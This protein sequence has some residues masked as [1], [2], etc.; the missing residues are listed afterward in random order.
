MRLSLYLEK[1]VN[2]SRA[3]S[4]REDLASDPAVRKATYISPERG[5]KEFEKYSGLGE[6]LSL[7]S[8]NPLPGVI[9]IEP[10]DTSSL[11]VSNL[12]NRLVHIGGIQEVRVDSEWLKRLNAMLELGNRI[13]NGVTLLIVTAVVLAV[14][15]TIRLLVANRRDEIRVTKLVGGSDGYVMLPFLYSGFWYGLLGGVLGWIMTA[16][17]WLLVSQPATHLASLYH[18]AFRPSFPGMDITL[19]LVVGGAL[20]GVLGALL[21]C[22]RQ[23]RAIDP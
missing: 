15:N 12:Q 17:L 2:Q 22:W 6:A 10:I 5:L 8:S 4:I 1:G 13:L 16:C 14:G 7:L 9:E 11:A 23:I 18:N 3:S 20:M 19:L 21:A